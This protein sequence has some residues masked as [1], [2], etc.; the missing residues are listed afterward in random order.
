MKYWIALVISLVALTGLTAC[1]GD[2][3]SKE[4]GRISAIGDFSEKTVNAWV[5]NG[6]SGIY[7]VLHARIVEKCSPEDFLAAMADQPQPSAWR[8]TKDILIQGDDQASATATVI[9]VVDGKDVE[10]T[11]GFELENNVRWRITDVPGLSG[12][13]SQ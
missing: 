8:N 5:A 6:P 4:D 12:C 2:D 9:I 10:Q 11:W 13:S 1:G 7:N 3:N